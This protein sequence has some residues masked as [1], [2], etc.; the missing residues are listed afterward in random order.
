MESQIVGLPSGFLYTFLKPV[1]V[2]LKIADRVP[3]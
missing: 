1:E 2:I 3:T